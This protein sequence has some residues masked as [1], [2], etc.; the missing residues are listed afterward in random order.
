MLS[1]LTP[2][3]E[4][5]CDGPFPV[6]KSLRP[7][8]RP[9]VLDT[10]QKRPWLCLNSQQQKKTTKLCPAMIRLHFLIAGERW[11]TSVPDDIEKPIVGHLLQHIHPSTQ[12]F[13][14]HCDWEI[15]TLPVASL[16]PLLINKFGNIRY[17]A[18][19]LSKNQPITNFAQITLWVV[20]YSAGAL[21]IV[22]L[23]LQ[24]DGYFY[25]TAVLTGKLSQQSWQV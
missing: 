13:N 23:V 9:L 14:Y 2:M 11:P 22:S 10:L 21:G 19:K 4:V 16:V 7:T 1:Y 24:N 18:P 5:S 20:A 6:S 15:G 17:P 8:M 25:M 12:F 3:L